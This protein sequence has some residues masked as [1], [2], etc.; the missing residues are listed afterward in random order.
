MARL[1]SCPDTKPP[2][3]LLRRVF[4]QPVKAPRFGPVFQG[5]PSGTANSNC[6]T[7]AKNAQGWDTHIR[8][9]LA[10]TKTRLGHQTARRQCD[11]KA[12]MRLPVTSPSSAYDRSG[13]QQ[14]ERRL[15][16]L[17]GF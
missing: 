7:R 4:P 1:K 5:A 11:S 15:A 9:Q 2:N 13:S 3:L 6:S 12:E 14:V 8:G 16:L 10:R 17:P